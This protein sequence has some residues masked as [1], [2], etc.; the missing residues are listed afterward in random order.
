MI[1][2]RSDAVKSNIIKA[3]CYK[4]AANIF[5]NGEKLKAFHLKSGIRRGC[6]FSSLLFNIAMEYL[7][8]AIREEKEIKGIQIGK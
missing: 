1:E 7:A 3:I 5:L 2:A 6:P 4:P 8:T